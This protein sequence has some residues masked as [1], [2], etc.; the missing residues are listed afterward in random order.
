MEL[1][2]P[3]D[4]LG[5]GKE[6]DAVELETIEELSEVTDELDVTEELLVIMDDELVMN[7]LEVPEEEISEV[8]EELVTEELAILEEV[9]E[10]EEENDA[11]KDDEELVGSEG[12]GLTEV[13]DD[14]EVVVIKDGELGGAVDDVDAV[15]LEEIV[16]SELDEADVV[17]SVDAELTRVEDVKLA[18]LEESGVVG[19]ADVEL[20]EVVDVKLAELEESDVV[21]SV[22]VELA[23]VEE[24]EVAE[25]EELEDDN[26]TYGLLI[27]TRRSMF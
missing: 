7:E 17:L 1:S 10:I 11:D 22:D 20:A 5:L 4:E 8:T 15:E 23:D 25:L 16:L 27:R 2:G 14:T 19:S 21:D 24:V 26:A 12:D 6:L 13:A 9:A 18:E 3:A